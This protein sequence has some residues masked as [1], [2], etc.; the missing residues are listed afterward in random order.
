MHFMTGRHNR[1]NWT[2]AAT[3]PSSVNLMVPGLST[4]QRDI[5]VT[6][7]MDCKALFYS[8][9]SNCSGKQGNRI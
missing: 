1:F 3:G 7:L 2:K 4:G 6:G 9:Y 8:P 5:P